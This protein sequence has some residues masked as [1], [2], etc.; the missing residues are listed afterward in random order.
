M[1]LSTAAMGY[2][3]K[4]NQIMKEFAFFKQSKL[5]KYEK[6]SEL[7][8]LAGQKFK[9]GQQYNDAIRCYLDA[10]HAYSKVDDIVGAE[11]QKLNA[12]RCCKLNSDY[13]RLQLICDTLSHPQHENTIDGLAKLYQEVG[14][15]FDDINTADANANAKHDHQ[16]SIIW[17]QKALYYFQLSSHN[18]I[19][20][21]QNIQVRLAD[22]FAWTDC[23]DKAIDMYSVTL[24][25]MS[26]SGLGRWTLSDCALKLI[27]CQILHDSDTKNFCMS[28]MDSIDERFA[29]KIIFFIQSPPPPQ[30]LD[31]VIQDYQKRKP[32]KPLTQY[33][34]DKIKMICQNKT[35][36]AYQNSDIDLT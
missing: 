28:F 11:T 6:A 22:L 19:V 9:I 13:Q 14:E 27:L 4:A 20:T 2:E 5:D 7:F 25:K 33:L 16:Q 10:A 24:S 35:I 23:Y 17:L 31:D 8:I 1:H 3:Y 18:R 21:I 32:M 30:E 29:A 15:D 26:Q 36:S 34:L 12:A